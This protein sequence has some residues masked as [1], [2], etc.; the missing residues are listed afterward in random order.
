[1]SELINNYSE[2]NEIIFK[3]KKIAETLKALGEDFGFDDETCVEIAE[4][5]FED[6]FE[7]SYSYLVQAGLDPEEVLANFIESSKQIAKDL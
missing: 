2:E 3:S 4:M 7:A 6:A 1:M 5:P